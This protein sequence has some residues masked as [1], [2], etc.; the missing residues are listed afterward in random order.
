M[1]FFT[2][3]NSFYIIILLRTKFLLFNDKV[4][5]IIMKFY[6]HLTSNINEKKD[7]ILFTVKG[8]V[9]SLLRFRQLTLYVLHETLLCNANETLTLDT[10]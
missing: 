2:L 4:Y 7:N 8:G 5:C 9:N 10:I 1:L 6:Y 3:H